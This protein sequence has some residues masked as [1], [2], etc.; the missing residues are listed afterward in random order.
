[1]SAW[2][3]ITRA[4]VMCV[5]SVSLSP[6]R[7]ELRVDYRK[8]YLELRFNGVW[9]PDRRAEPTVVHGFARRLLVLDLLDQLALR[10]TQSAGDVRVLGD[11]YQRLKARA[12]SYAL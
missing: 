9:M 10:I 12:G 2:L 6:G 7:S 1:M 3:P 11:R 4:S 8:L 5:M